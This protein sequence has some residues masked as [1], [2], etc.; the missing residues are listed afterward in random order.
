MGF[1]KFHQKVVEGFISRKRHTF[2]G[3]NIFLDTQSCEKETVPS[4][5]YP[6]VFRGEKCCQDSTHMRTHTHTLSLS[7][8]LSLSLF[9]YLFLC[10]TFISSVETSHPK[11]SV[12]Q[13]K[14][15]VIRITPLKLL[16]PIY[17]ILCKSETDLCSF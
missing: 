7:L 10:V 1:L 4:L 9:L 6:Q 12:H 14:T 15:G 16:Y 17:C 8:S 3:E 13:R 11:V 2:I 5:L